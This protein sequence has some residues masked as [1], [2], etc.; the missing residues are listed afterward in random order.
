MIKPLLIVLAVG[1]VCFVP[2]ASLGYDNDNSLEG[3]LT[4]VMWG[5]ILVI[6]LIS[7]GAMFLPRVHR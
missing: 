5:F 4:G 7:I 2:A 6:A 3:V 1:V